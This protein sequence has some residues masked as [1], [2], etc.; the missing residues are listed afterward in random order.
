MAK[1]PGREKIKVELDFKPYSMLDASTKKAIDS[2]PELKKGFARAVKWSD[3][4]EADPAKYDK[5][6]LEYEMELVARWPYQV[7]GTYMTDAIKK[8]GKDL[9][10]AKASA[11]KD[12]AEAEKMIP[13]RCEKKLEELV[14]GKEDNAKAEKRIEGALDQI[15]DVDFN[16]AF[17]KPRTEIAGALKEL[18]KALKGSGDKKRAIDKAKKAFESAKAKFEEVGADGQDAIDYLLKTARNLKN[19]KKADTALK[20]VGKLFQDEKG[21]FDS[22]EKQSEKFTKAMQDTEKLFEDDEPDAAKVETLAGEFD[23]LSGLDKAA[24]DIQTAMKGIKK[25]YEDTKKALNKK[26]K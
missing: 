18:S 8:G 1:I 12:L 11:I 21:T 26:K 10:K 16:G 19:D 3:T 23:K 24:Q 15:D 17:E 14:S 13:R 2:I 20:N 7:I 6:D 5:K 9:D 4:V 22:F 25:K